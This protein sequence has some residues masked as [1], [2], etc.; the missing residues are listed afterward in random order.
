MRIIITTPAPTIVD[1]PILD[2][3]EGKLFT[4]LIAGSISARSLGIRIGD[5][6]FFAHS[7]DDSFRHAGEGWRP[8]DVKYVAEVTIK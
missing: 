8:F 7:G 6:G 5:R 4:Y 2:V 3:Q 1:T